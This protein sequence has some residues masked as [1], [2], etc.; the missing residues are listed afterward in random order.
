M[1]E[2]FTELLLDGG[3]IETPDSAPT[4]PAE[5]WEGIDRD[6]LRTSYE[7]SIR[8]AGMSTYDRMTPT[9][10]ELMIKIGMSDELEK[11]KTFIARPVPTNRFGRRNTAN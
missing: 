1:F 7:E 11:D 3:Y 6:Y 5:Y 9:A 8:T 2:H 10:R 4:I